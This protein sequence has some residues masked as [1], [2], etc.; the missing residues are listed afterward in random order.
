MARKAPQTA[1]GSR[2]R[3]M[4]LCNSGR[5]FKANVVVLAGTECKLAENVEIP[6]FWPDENR[7]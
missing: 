7:I 5:K 6:P 1:L 2:A 3:L 4:Q